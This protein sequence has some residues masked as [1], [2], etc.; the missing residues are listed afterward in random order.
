[1]KPIRIAILSASVALLVGCSLFQNEVPNTSNVRLSRAMLDSEGR[2]VLRA[3]EFE[4]PVNSANTTTSITLTQTWFPP[5][6]DG[7]HYIQ[8]FDLTV[9]QVTNTDRTNQLSEVKAR[10][11]RDVTVEALKAA[12]TAGLLASGVPVAPGAGEAIGRALDTAMNPKDEPI[13]QEWPH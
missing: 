5:T 7:T 9:V 10:G 4:M 1:M 12:V 3:E 11:S 2:V 6:G 8:D 13:E